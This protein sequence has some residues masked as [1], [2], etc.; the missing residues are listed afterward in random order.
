MK[1]TSIVVSLI[2]GSL[3]GRCSQ[4]KVNRNH[5]DSPVTVQ[6]AFDI[7]ELIT[8]EISQIR[9]VLGE[10][11]SDWKPN[12]YQIENYPS[13]LATIEYRRETTSILIDYSQTGQI[14][15][16]FISDLT[17]GRSADEILA[18][19]NLDPNSTK[20]S[21]R[22]RDWGNPTYARS[23]KAAESAGIEVIPK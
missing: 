8:M 12:E 14:K 21:L 7:P 19:G 2:F 16:I 9:K 11:Y 10:S 4:D 18:L 22:F 15:N 5:D 1:L 20:Y 6:A 17:E 3:I 13:I 23:Q